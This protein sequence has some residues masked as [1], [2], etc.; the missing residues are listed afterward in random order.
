[1]FNALEQARGAASFDA[2]IEAVSATPV[3]PAGAPSEFDYP[4]AIR[5]S[6]QE[7]IGIIGAILLEDCPELL[8]ELRSGAASGDYE[9]LKRAIHTLKGLLANFSETPALS[10]VQS[11]DELIGSGRHA[12]AL[13]L[14]NPIEVETAHFLESLEV[15]LRDHR[16][17]Q[18]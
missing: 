13:E 9:L 12:S 4:A 15:H 7:V 14:L 1:L 18:A 10:I 5:A 17:G 2:S 8:G 16:A 11:A 6:D 3:A